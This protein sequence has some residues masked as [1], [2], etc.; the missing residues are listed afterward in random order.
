MTRLS[1]IHPYPGMIADDLAIE[2]AR[3]YVRHGDR[4]LDPFCGTGRTLM[5]SAQQGAHAVGV[6]MNPLA[7][8]LV[9][10]KAATPSIAILRRLA[11]DLAIASR[12]TM[13]I[14]VYDFEQGRKVSWFSRKA[15]RELSLLI[16]VLNQRQLRTQELLLVASILSATAR[17]V[18]Y[19]RNDQWK[20]HRMP[21]SERS[22][23]KKSPFKAFLN[24]LNHTINDLRSSG[25]LRGSC[26][27]LLGDSRDLNAVL[28]NGLEHRHF[29]LIFSSPPY[30]DSKTTVQ[31]GGVSSLC[32][33]VLKHLKKLELGS[34][35]SLSIDHSCLGGIL[36][37]VM[38]FEQTT[39][40]NLRKYWSGDTENRMRRRVNSY[41]V[42][43][44]ECCNRMVSALKVKGMV[45]L[46]VARRT[47][48]GC[49]L[50]LDRYLVDEMQNLGC[51]CHRVKKRRISGKLTPYV[52]HARGNSGSRDL[53]NKY[54]VATMREEYVLFF[55]KIRSFRSNLIRP[56]ILNKL[57][58]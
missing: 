11:E 39:S 36:K 15:K 9:A 32:L 22:V 49:K 46:V 29:D 7:K 43:L 45:I 40:R 56:S 19:C 13:Q 30:G 33:G 27:A 14:P 10:A 41:L 2:L 51:V 25:P 3:S 55:K 26:K 50:K 18:S 57:P 38:N 48:G 58:R 12:Q 54:R 5:A 23:F 35:G 16:F 37:P 28:R 1:R 24:R 47:V 6:D 53:S 20:I 52:I 8:L 4:V 21:P 17:E 42:D 44:S 31:Y 34:Q